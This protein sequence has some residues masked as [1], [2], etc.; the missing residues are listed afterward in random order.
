MFENVNT[1]TVR[2]KSLIF[3][4]DFIFIAKSDGLM[5]KTKAFAE[6]ISRIK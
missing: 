6:S 2:L 1:H 4:F 5:N 3:L